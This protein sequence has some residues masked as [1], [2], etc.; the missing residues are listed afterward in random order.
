MRIH[1]DKLICVIDGINY[2]WV[3][4][5]GC[6]LKSWERKVKQGEMRVIG[7][8]IFHATR[9]YKHFLAPKKEICWITLDNYSIENIRAIK[10]EIFE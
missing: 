2:E 8:V 1:P 7:D 9:V 4:G 6:I 5:F 10:K 3:G